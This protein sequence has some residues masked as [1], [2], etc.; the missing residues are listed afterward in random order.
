MKKEFITYFDEIELASTY[1]DAAEKCISQV[2]KIYDLTVED[3][4]VC[5]YL[6]EGHVDVTSLWIIGAEFLVECKDFVNSSNYDYVSFKN[7]LKYISIEMNGVDLDADTY[8]NDAMVKIYGSISSSGT[9]SCSL[10]AC[11]KNC[12]KGIEVYRK[13]FV[14]NIIK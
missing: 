14:S 7:N 8:E 3:I 2:E 12:R 5:T 9:L 1:R 6:N 13:Y 11:G 10:L 4:F